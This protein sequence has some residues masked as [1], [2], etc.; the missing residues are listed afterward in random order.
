MVGRHD[1]CGA[2]ARFQIKSVLILHFFSKN[3]TH[4]LTLI[5]FLLPF[6]QF[7]NQE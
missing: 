3:N 6:S 7:L 4:I 5:Y 1:D 2:K